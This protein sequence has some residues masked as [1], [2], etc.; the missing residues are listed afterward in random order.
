MSAHSDAMLAIVTVDT[1]LMGFLIVFLTGFRQ[2]VV[3]A[4]SD[5]QWLADLVYGAGLAFVAVTLVGD[6]LE[7]GAALD[8]AGS[9]PNAVV[10][11]ALTEAHTLLFGAT[12]CLLTA[13]ILGVAGYISRISRVVPRWTGILAYVVAG[14]NLVAAAAV[15]I[16]PADTVAFSEAGV[17]VTALSTFPW[18]V[19]VVT[20]GI[21]T[22]RHAPRGPESPWR[23][24]RAGAGCGSRRRVTRP[25]RARP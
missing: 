12:G 22:I 3:R 20:I 10:L 23:C 6:S 16:R 17:A 18:L 25:W 9:H 1:A 15:F 4:R 2:L 13:L 24:S 21:C 14:S 5:L 8:A 19:W 11:Q 7:G